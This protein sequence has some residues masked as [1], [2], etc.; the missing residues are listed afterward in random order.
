MSACSS[1]SFRSL[2]LGRHLGLFLGYLLAP[3]DGGFGADATED[4][5]DTENLHVRQAVAEGDD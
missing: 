3:R 1:L 4:E 2:G 5:A